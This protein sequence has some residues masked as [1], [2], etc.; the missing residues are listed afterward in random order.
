MNYNKLFSNSVQNPYSSQK[1]EG[2]DLN[3]S[4]KLVMELYSYVSWVEKRIIYLDEIR[5]ITKEILRDDSSFEVTIDTFSAF[6]SYFKKEIKP[7]LNELFK[8][9]I[10]EPVDHENIIKFE[11]LLVLIKEPFEEIK[12]YP[13]INKLAVEE[14]N[15]WFLSLVETLENSVHK[16]F[17][18][19][20]KMGYNFEVLSQVNIEIAKTIPEKTPTNYD[21]RNNFY[22]DPYI[23][24]KT[25][26]S[27]VTAA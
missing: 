1:S 25:P 11:K 13:L 22:I 8:N 3:N 23:G 4:T 15:I 26:S 27:C 17:K 12:N 6:N 7:S 21:N 19:A 16:L 18:F 24:G 14:L 5:N 10:R 9:I 2:K 20:K